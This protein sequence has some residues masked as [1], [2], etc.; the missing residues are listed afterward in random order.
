MFMKITWARPWP[1]ETT[2]I[3]VYADPSK[4]TCHHDENDGYEHIVDNDGND[5]DDDDDD[6]DDDNDDEDDDDQ[7]APEVSLAGVLPRCGCAKHPPCD[8]R[9]KIW[10]MK[11][12]ISDIRYEI[13]LWSEIQDMR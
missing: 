2:P 12:K 11:Y 9:Y 4:V 13:S 5:Y 1:Q 3:R 7:G 8:L 6:D 10:D